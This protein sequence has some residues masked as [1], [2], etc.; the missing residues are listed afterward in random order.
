MAPGPGNY[1]IP[2]DEQARKTAPSFGF[3][4]GGP[5][6]CSRDFSVKPAIPGPG[7]YSAK[8]AYEAGM[9]CGFGSEARIPVKKIAK[10]P[11]P[12]TYTRGS[13]L[14]TQ[15]MTIKGRFEA[16]DKKA[17][18]TPAP[19]QYGTPSMDSVVDKL[20]DVPCMRMTEDR[21][22]TGVF[23]SKSIAPAPGKYE[24]MKEFGSGNATTTACPRFTMGSRRRP[25]KK[26]SGPGPGSIPHYTQ[27][28]P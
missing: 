8:S 26:D 28:G 19:G 11:E 20:Q 16:K 27:F 18:A 17:H 22:K 5:R 24:M 7:T 6:L 12:G 10:A 1:G 13:T 25:V 15:N 2:C 4:G 3:G 14:S 23:V 21:E 9:S